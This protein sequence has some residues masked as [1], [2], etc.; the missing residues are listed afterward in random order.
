M[1]PTTLSESLFDL[2]LNIK[3]FFFSAVAFVFIAVAMS[4]KLIYNQLT[5]WYMPDVQK[6]VVRLLWLVPLY[7]IQSL[8]SLL[9]HDLRLYFDTL[10]DLYEAFVIQSFLYYLM[11][12][13][14]GEDAIVSI[15][16]EKDENY[17]QHEVGFEFFFFQWD[18]GLEFML[19]CKRGVL[20]YVVVK[21]L[22]AIATAVLE[23]F[24]LYCEG[25]FDWSKG[26]IYISFFLN[27]SQMWAL[28]CLIK[29]YHA[30]SDNLRHPV[31][32]RPLG[33]FLCVKGVVF[34]TW[35]QGMLI[36]VLRSRNIIG[37][38]GTWNADQVAS[39]LQ[40]YLVC[41]EMF[42]FAIA[43]AFTFTHK[44]YL[45]RNIGG[46][47][48]GT[49]ELLHYNEGSRYESSL[50]MDESNIES[51]EVGEEVE[52]TEYKPPTI[53][54]LRNPM[55]FKNAIWESLF[56]ENEL[57]EIKRLRNG[58]SDQVINQSSDLGMINMA[59]MQYAESI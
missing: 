20:Q 9:F 23:P 57:S 47:T 11:E 46:G 39:G 3:A 40:D 29:F 14:G 5:N 26:Y 24:N 7:A 58:V 45:P 32:W 19:Q 10:R 52:N 56:M 36:A 44:E 48:D 41:V 28:Y 35:W 34:F 16:Q 2:N 21:T 18:M 22:G 31:N 6:Y 4:M 37:S 27:V 42:C 51:K 25:E 17:G 33:K 49:E 54:T 13:L 59:S 50:C 53:R 30:T 8:L 1:T 15:L 55:G 12:I 43:H 38:V